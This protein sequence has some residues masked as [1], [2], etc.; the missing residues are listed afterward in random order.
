MTDVLPLWRN[1]DPETSK[2]A[3][4]VV[5]PHLNK[6]QRLV[7]DVYKK[8]GPMTARDAEQLPECADYG[9]STIRKRISELYRQDLLLKVGVDDS[10][11]APCT[12][13]RC[14]S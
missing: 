3:G 12:I 7:L 14:E 8:H 9:F 6:I 2:D 4:R 5:L 1:T 13:Y 10:G 11:R